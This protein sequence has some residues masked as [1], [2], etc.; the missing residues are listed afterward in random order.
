MADSPT[1]YGDRRLSPPNK[2]QA[3]PS[4]GVALSLLVVALVLFL[5]AAVVLLV[6]VVRI[7]VTL[8]QDTGVDVVVGLIIIVFLALVL[9]GYATAT[10]ANRKRN[11]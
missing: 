1:P 2:G 3:A 4:R 9:S 6:A 8:S 11:N 5:A 7:W 10:A